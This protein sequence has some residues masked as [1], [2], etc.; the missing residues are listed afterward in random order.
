[1][2]IGFVGCGYTA[3]QYIDSVKRYPYLNLAA[4]T[5]R[6]PQRASE[7]CAYHSV[8]LCPTLEAMLADPKIEMVVN[9]TSPS[10]HFAV[11]KAC[12]EAGKHLYSE[13][14]LAMT[15][16]EAQ[17]LVELARAK[18]LYLS[19][20]PC[21]VLGETAQT[22]WRA[23]RNREIGT[24][25]LAYAD[26]DDGPLHLAGPHLWRSPSG[27][28]YDYKEEYMTGTTL[29]HAGYYLSWFAAF[30]GPA[31]N[32]TAFAACLWPDKQ[33]VPEE[34]LEQA[35]DFSVACITFGSGA[36]VRLT[37]SS[38]AP[39]N[40]G[41][42]I[43]G[44]T[45]VLAVDECWNFSAPVYLDRYSKLKFRVERYPITKAYPFMKRWADPRPRTYSPVKRS[46]WKKRLARY[47]MDYARG[48]AELARAITERRPSRLPADYCLHVT[49]LALAI[50]NAN[51]VPYQIRT[52]F[53]PLQ[54]MDTTALKEMIPT[55]W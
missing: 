15:F 21:G 7:F 45:G 34:R 16:S 19:V 25:H 53:E 2:R 48:I 32:I 49:E 50:H 35:S 13:K 42:R 4:V 46:S 18:G 52:S 9:L 29:E 11:S 36:V 51:S 54:P 27:A 33:V 47:R 39:Y 44:D 5:D 22:L 23:L 12:L 38:V 30:F 6:D 20:A 1:M 24:V 37:C 31:K 26:I 14:P 43:V 55:K 17:T 41:M 28:P 8:P 40:H 3:D 10:S